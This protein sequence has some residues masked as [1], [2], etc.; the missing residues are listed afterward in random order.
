MVRDAL[1]GPLHG[2]GQQRLLD[3][4]LAGVE[5]A[6]PADERAEGLRSEPAQQVL[7]GA[8]AAH[9]SN[10]DGS[11]IGLTSTALYRASGKRAAISV[12]RSRLSQ[13]MTK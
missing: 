10:P 1:A 5:V 8:G 2:G 3:R 9:I 12:A 7:G 13:S 6:V 11:M 4:V